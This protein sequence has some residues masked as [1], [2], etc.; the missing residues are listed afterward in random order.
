MGN[1]EDDYEGLTDRQIEKKVL[2][3]IERILHEKTLS[4]EE[5][6]AGIFAQ[7]QYAHDY[8]LER[9]GLR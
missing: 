4:R 5:K 8:M 9:R 3:E 6:L 2:Q 1:S 7:A